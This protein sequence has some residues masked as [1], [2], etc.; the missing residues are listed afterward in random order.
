MLKISGRDTA[1]FGE[2]F[3]LG[4]SYAKVLYF[5]SQKDMKQLELHFNSQTIWGF[6]SLLPH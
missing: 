6:E 5:V 2:K 3:L 1:K 4:N